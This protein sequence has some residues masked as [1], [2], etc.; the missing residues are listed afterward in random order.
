MRKFLTFLAALLFAS[1]AFALTDAE[2]LAKAEQYLNGISTLQARF[3]QVN[4]DGSSNEGD[5]YISRPGKMRLVYDPPTPMLMV[6]DGVFLIYVDTQMKDVSHIDLNDTP[7]GLLLKKDL[8]FKD[9][10]IKLGGVK[11]ATGTVEIA[12]SLAK[13]PTAGKLTLVFTEAPFELKQWRVLDAQRKE[14]VVTLD[15]IRLGGKMDPALFKYEA[16]KR[17]QDRGDKN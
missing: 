7:A 13:D 16:R 9:P 8:T 1:P 2:A 6:A 5:L 15:N 3:T 10:D 11:A 4:P 12:A 14:V 17:G